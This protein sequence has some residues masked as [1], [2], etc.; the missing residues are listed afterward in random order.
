MERA[1]VRLEKIPRHLA[2]SLPCRLY[3]QGQETRTLFYNQCYGI[4][5]DEGKAI[6]AV[7][8][9]NRVVSGFISQP[10]M[11]RYFGVAFASEADTHGAPASGILFIKKSAAFLF[12]KRIRLHREAG[13]L[14]VFFCSAAFPKEAA[15]PCPCT[16]WGGHE[17]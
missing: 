8:P 1:K 16:V 15:L 11:C 9:H 7:R 13:H 6:A 4:L 12:S 3:S 2:L 17:A 14:G 5:Q 10:D